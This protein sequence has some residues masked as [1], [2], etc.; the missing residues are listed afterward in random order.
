MHGIYNCDDHTLV[1][2][3]F[4]RYIALNLLCLTLL[5]H[6]AHQKSLTG[7]KK[8]AVQPTNDQVAGKKNCYLRCSNIYVTCL[9]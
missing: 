2:K 4:G 5:A 6:A 3:P 8:N 7:E 1:F 9:R